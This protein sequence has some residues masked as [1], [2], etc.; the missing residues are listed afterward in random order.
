MKT[1]FWD[2]GQNLS[3]INLGFGGVWLCSTPNLIFIPD[4]TA[5]TSPMARRR[6]CSMAGTCKAKHNV[7]NSLTWGPDGWLYG[8][9][10]ILS[11]SRSAA[12]ALPTP[13]ACRS[14]AASGAI[15]RPGRS[16]KPS[17][18]APRIPGVST[19]TTR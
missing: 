13:T 7:F 14:T 5:T 9:N 1:V 15:I 3:G 12:R 16:S 11:N 6:S 4:Q 10:G 19:S 2:K 18:T 17:P 8:C